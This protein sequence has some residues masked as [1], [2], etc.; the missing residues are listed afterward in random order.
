[1]KAYAGTSFLVSLYT[2]DANS[3]SAAAQMKGV[4]AVVLLTPF[5]ELELRNA[6]ELRVFR[7]ELTPSEVE[8]A[9]AALREDIEKGIYALRPFPGAAFERAKEIAHK[10]T[11]RLGTRTLDILHVAS[12]LIL[13]ADAFYSFDRNQR[14]LARAE[15]LKIP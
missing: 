4:R 6:L 12:A 5:G 15:G 13:Q 3:T 14:K 8:A 7:G 1:L 9:R 2:P 11:A 10:R